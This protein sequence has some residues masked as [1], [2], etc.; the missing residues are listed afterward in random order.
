VIR[1]PSSMERRA[2]ATSK[3]VSAGIERKGVFARRVQD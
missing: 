1:E 2:A 3:I